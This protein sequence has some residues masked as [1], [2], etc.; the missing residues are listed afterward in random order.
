[1]SSRQFSHYPASKR[2]SGRELWLPR[3]N[4]CMCAKRGRQMRAH[5]VSNCWEI[6]Y[7]TDK[8]IIDFIR[9]QI[10]PNCLDIFPFLIAS[11]TSGIPGQ[12]QVRREQNREGWSIVPVGLL[13]THPM[14]W[15]ENGNAHKAEKA[16]PLKS[17]LTGSTAQ[18]GG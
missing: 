5:S 2:K 14:C 6:Y 18:V 3:G 9:Y 12:T 13:G 17:D 7:A 10:L 16:K 11:F 1:M 15:C 4:V 8:E